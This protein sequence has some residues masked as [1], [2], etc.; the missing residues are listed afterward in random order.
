MAMNYKTALLA[1]ECGKVE[2]IW[3]MKSDQD[4]GKLLKEADSAGN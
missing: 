3:M 1:A 4:A 2:K